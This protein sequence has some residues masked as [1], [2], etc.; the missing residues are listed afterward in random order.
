MRGAHLHIIRLDSVRP[1]DEAY[2][3]ALQYGIAVPTTYLTSALNVL[4]CHCRR[5][6]LF[7]A[8]LRTDDAD[9]G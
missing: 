8:F 5:L 4:T 7:R 6:R 1:I 2:S 3:R 9:A